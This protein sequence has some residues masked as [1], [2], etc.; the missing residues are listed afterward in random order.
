MIVV[1]SFDTDDRNG[2]IFGIKAQIQQKSELRT[3]VVPLTGKVSFALSYFISKN[4][5][6]HGINKIGN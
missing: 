5:K 3:K 6:C 2:F 1:P 4:I